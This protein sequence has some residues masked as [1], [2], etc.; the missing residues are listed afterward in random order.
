MSG[1]RKFASSRGCRDLIVMAVVAEAFFVALS[2]VVAEIALL[3]GFA[4]YLFRWKFDSGY[5]YRKSPVFGAILVFM[6]CGGASVLVSPDRGFSFY[7]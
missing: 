3:L 1:L 6:L 5:H 7:N 4:V 2:P